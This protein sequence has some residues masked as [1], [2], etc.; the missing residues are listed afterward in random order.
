MSFSNCNYH[1]LYDEENEDSRDLV[2]M[3]CQIAGIEAVTAVCVT[4]A[5]ETAQVQAFDLYLL[6]SRFPDGSGLD[7]CR[8]LRAL[9]PLT[10][11]LIYSG[12]AYEADRKKGFA[13][14]AS[15]YLVKPYMADLAVTIR[16]HIEQA[17]D[18]VRQSKIIYH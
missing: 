7:L 14:G 1:I 8:R 10:P 6:D 5:W 15:D 18:T 3:I 17:R 13:A 2:S 9:A 16:Q 4:E 11:I 12:D